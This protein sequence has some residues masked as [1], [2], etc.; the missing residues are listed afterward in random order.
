MLF[1]AFTSL[2]W[3]QNS[4]LQHKNSDYN[5]GLN[6]NVDSIFQIA[7]E[8]Y[9][10]D[11]F[12]ESISLYEKIINRNI[13]NKILYYNIGNAYYK[14]NQLGYARLFYEKAKLYDSHDS[15]INHNI[16]I[17]KNKMT[18]KSTVLKEFFLLQIFKD[19]RNYFSSSQWLLITL[20]LLYINLITLLLLLFIKS[21]RF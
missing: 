18:Y 20:L 6:L 1:I 15:D 11:E 14:L 7:N 4:K 13:D 19:I 3:S 9:K 17:I 2:V 10:K 16:N 5:D 8:L 21:I 12:Q